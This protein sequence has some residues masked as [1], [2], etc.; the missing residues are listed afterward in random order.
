MSTHAP[1]SFASDDV[2]APP[3]DLRGASFVTLQRV[4]I[5]R[6]GI[7]VLALVRY[8]ESPVGAYLERAVAVMTRRGPSVIEMQV[9]SPASM[10][11]GR[12]GWGYPKT[13]ADLTWR[14]T[15]EMTVFNARLQNREHIYRARAF[16][17]SFPIRVRAWSAQTL[18]GKDVRAPFQL[19]GRARLAKVNRRL[20]VCIESFEMRVLP[21]IEV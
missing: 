2:P 8:D 7:A 16:G 15:N 14:E 5:R 19:R 3:W 10:R 13:L 1:A 11:G 12:R 4:S 20:G 9:S 18:N 6:G 17:P 21:P